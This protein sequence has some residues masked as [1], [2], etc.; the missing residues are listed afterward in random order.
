MSEKDHEILNE[1]TIKNDNETNNIP[2]S[3]EVLDVYNN[4]ITEEAEE[5]L[6]SNIELENNSEELLDETINYIADNN[7]NNNNKITF[8]ISKQH[9]NDYINN[10]SKKTSLLPFKVFLVAF[11]MVFIGHIYLEV[12]KIIGIIGLFLAIV[13]SIIVIMVN[14]QNKRQADVYNTDKQYEWLLDEEEFTV[15]EEEG[16]LSTKEIIRYADIVNLEETADFL[17]IVTKKNRAYFL[18]KEAL[19][20]KQTIIKNKILKVVKIYNNTPIKN[21]DLIRGKYDYPKKDSGQIPVIE[22]R[23]KVGDAFFYTIVIF[24]IIAIG[25]MGAKWPSSI[26]LLFIPVGIIDLIYMI[27]LNKKIPAPFKP[28]K[29]LICIFILLVLSLILGSLSLLFMK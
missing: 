11:L 15:L 23:R 25:I 2:K 10:N 17:I 21:E 28:K 8:T 9:I 7:N 12:L 24:S 6:E 20:D 3:E 5:F 13:I 26:I 19:G 27:K 18:D 4:Q 14:S 22:G 29:E 16:T 1:Q